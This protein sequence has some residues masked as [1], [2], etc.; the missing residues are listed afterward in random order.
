[1]HPTRFHRS[2][3]AA[4][5]AALASAGGGC[6]PKAASATT[7]GSDFSGLRVSRVVLYTNGI[8]YFERSGKLS[9]EELT[10]RIRA[11]Q[12]NDF[13][14]S[15]TIV[16]RSGG[17]AVS[18]SLP[19]ERDAALTI[20]ELPPA[21]RDA[22]GL[23][24]VLES[25][26]GARVKVT[27]ALFDP[28]RTVGATGRVVGLDA[29]TGVARVT[30]L[31]DTGKMT[32]IP[33]D[34]I[35]NLVL[36]DKTLE[37]GL[38]KGLDMALGEGTWK[39]VEL[40][41]RLRGKKSHDLVLGY[42]IEM[43]V[44]KPAYRLVVGD[45][46]KN[47]LLQGWAVVDNTSGEAWDHVRLSLAAGTPLSFLYD[48]HAPRIVGRPD[49][50][51]GDEVAVAPP[52]AVGYASAAPPPPPPMPAPKAAAAS[53]GY[54]DADKKDEGKMS[55][56][57]AKKKGKKKPASDDKTGDAYGGADEESAA[58]EP[59]APEPAMTLDALSAAMSPV[60][61][62]TTV[63]GLLTYDIGSPVSVPDRSSSLVS[64]IDEKIPGEDVYLYQPEASALAR[65]HPFRAARFVNATPFVLEKGPIAIYSG[66]TFVGEGLLG[67][68]AAGSETFVPYAMDTRVNVVVSNESGEEEVVLA[69]IVKGV[70]TVESYMFRA[71][72]YRL[73]NRTEKAATV[74]LRHPKSPGWDLK[75]RPE[76]TKE[77][78]GVYL[79][80][81][82]MAPTGPTE[83]VLK[84]R[85]PY[86]RT[87]EVWADVVPDLL[88]AYLK[89]PD[90]DPVLAK[91][92]DELLAARAKLGS[93]EEE[94]GAIAK[95]LEDLRARSS[96]LR[97]NLESLKKTA[98]ADALRA[99]LMKK[100]KG[101]D[102]LID[103]RTKKLVTL[104][105]SAA[106]SRI[107]LSELLAELT[108][109]PKPKGPTSAPSK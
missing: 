8:G 89:R 105:E 64:I 101:V 2:L 61:T 55:K 97:D 92:L 85:T 44:W 53:A 18:V 40:T 107:R 17:S 86:V 34:S 31:D 66:G 49:L 35:T 57:D 102:D 1:V 60:V 84:E 67:R 78:G 59:A 45:D 32:A 7:E 56:T 109:E 25:V 43:P 77:E 22:G 68:I 58:D 94:R 96:D 72:K 13:L 24:K 103:E 37:I 63:A 83:I 74:Y 4:L 11:D 6:G 51:P 10:L 12:I 33:V 91:K 73:E 76:G 16:D 50:T 42:V 5:L 15:L 39:P 75:D 70:F 3:T 71:T 88:R 106:E 19:I 48:L 47:A 80:P 65:S 79:V 23:V 54:A 93:I 98:K 29:A 26:R 69:K 87:I 28:P 82:K 27:A 100:L 41:V 108:L 9:G 21:V 52:E 99:D 14:K 90:V 46:G 30:I 95:L 38:R 81:T 62:A 104:D 20:S 36:L